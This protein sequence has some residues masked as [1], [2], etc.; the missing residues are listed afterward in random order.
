MTSRTKEIR[1]RVSPYTRDRF[2]YVVGKIISHYRLSKKTALEDVL[3]IILD[4]A[5]EKLNE[6]SVVLVD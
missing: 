1:I 3:N 5:L 6:K 4:L 2:N